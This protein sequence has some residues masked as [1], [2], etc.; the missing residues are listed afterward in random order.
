MKNDGLPVDLFRRQGKWL[1]KLK[2]LFR[3]CQW[4]IC[5]CDRDGEPI[6]EGS[7]PMMGTL[8]L[9]IWCLRKK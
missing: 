8:V 3:Q 6:H 2:C 4:Q 5:G 9:C 7:T 1:R